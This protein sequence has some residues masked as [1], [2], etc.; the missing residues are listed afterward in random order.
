MPQP[1]DD[2]ARVTPTSKVSGCGLTVEAVQRQISK[3]P[4]RRGLAHSEL[5]PV[6]GQRDLPVALIVDQA[7]GIC[8]GVVDAPR[9]VP[10]NIG[11]LSVPGE[12]VDVAIRERR[13]GQAGGG[14]KQVRL[15]REHGQKLARPSDDVERARS[16]VDLRG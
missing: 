7:L 16:D 10:G 8:T 5:Q 9:L 2:R 1:C 11:I 6:P 14:Q 4:A 3:E 12:G 13:Y 15:R